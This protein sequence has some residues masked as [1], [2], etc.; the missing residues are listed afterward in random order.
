MNIGFV[1]YEWESVK[2]ELDSTLKL[3][4]EAI[5]RGHKVSLI[6]PYEMA[7]R[8]TC[9]WANCR[10]V[11]SSK[12]NAQDNFEFY[13]SC[14]LT[15][16]FIPMNNHDVVFFRDNPPLDT[17]VLNFMD[18]LEN[19]T[20]FINSI[21]GLR[22]AN[23]KIYPAT[24]AALHDNDDPKKRLIPLTTVSRNKKYLKQVIEAYELDKFILKPMDGFGGSGVI[25][26]DKSSKTSKYNVNSLLDFYIN[27]GGKNNYI[28]LQEYIETELKGD[29]RVIMLNGEPV[30]T[31]RR[32]P[33]N[34]DHRSNVHAGGHCVEHELD[35]TE[36]KLCEII[37][38]K[39]VE[40]GLF[41]VGLDLM[42]GKLI[43]VNVCSPGGFVEINETREIKIQK[44]VLDFAEKTIEKKNS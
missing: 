20:F 34:D 32:V 25:L 16:E 38:P 44:R 5:S 2:P 31:M 18:T 9:V 42:G 36:L 27:Q 3:I 23:N 40:D 39:L 43:E 1:M 37:G 33:G 30:G 4:Q 28:I 14:R 26:L 29:V 41:L 17:H 35:E 24:L 6:Y 19:D 7:I 21:S 13:N 8:R 22:K 12:P 10:I 11:E 15:E